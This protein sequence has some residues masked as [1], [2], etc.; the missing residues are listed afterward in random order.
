MTSITISPKWPGHDKYLT[1]FLIFSAVFNSGLSRESQIR[2]LPIID[3]IDHMLIP[4][5]ANQSQSMYTYFTYSFSVQT[6]SNTGT[7]EVFH[8]FLSLLLGLP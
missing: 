7:C 5:I 1:A 4:P 2:T 3:H 8:F 6:A